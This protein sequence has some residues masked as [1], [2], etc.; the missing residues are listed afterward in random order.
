LV[1]IV[2]RAAAACGDDDDTTGRDAAIGGDG[3]ADTDGD[4]D[5]DGD[6]G[7]DAGPPETCD[8]QGATRTI[9][10][11]FCGTQDQ[12]CAADGVWHDDGECIGGGEC[13]PGAIQR[14]AC[15]TCGTH[16]RVCSA[17]CEWRAWAACDENPAGECTSGV[18]ELTRDGCEAGDIQS[19]RCLEDCTWE[20]LRPCGP[21]C[22]GAPEDVAADAEEICIPGGPFVMGGA[23]PNSTN[24]DPEHEVVL[25]PY[26]IGRFEVTNERYR[27]C[28]ADGGCTDP[29]ERYDAYDADDRARR[30]VLGLAWD[31]AEDFCSWAGGRL[32]TEAEW[33]KAARG[34]SPD[35]RIFPWG[36][37]SPSCAQTQVGDCPGYAFEVEDIDSYPDGASPFGV[38][39]MVDGAYEVVAD[40]YDEGYYADSDLVDPRGPDVGDERVVRSISEGYAAEVFPPLTA[41]DR[42]FPTG[43]RCARSAE[44]R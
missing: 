18:E 35:R 15:G 6:A 3:D 25:Y 24:D 40:W 32:P 8:E 19:R 10:C 37:A 28:V 42:G 2:I 12:I 1:L 30:P 41:R 4:A 22:I 39:R 16:E 7:T 9:D 11:G 34:P 29:V 27:V 31:Q 5:G 17:S 13:D 23:D 38:E 33:E 20:L 21:D 43:V 36:D 14:E 44:E 26:F